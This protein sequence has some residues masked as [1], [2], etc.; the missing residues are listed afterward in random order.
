[1][2]LMLLILVFIVVPIVELWLILQVAELMGGGARGAALT[3]GLLV[4]DSLLGAALLRSQGRSVWRQF[5]G[6]IDAR[7]M[8]AREIVDG[9]FVIVGGVL[10]LTPGFLSDIVGILMLIP[11]TRRIFGG[12]VIGLLSSRVRPAFTIADT[13]LSNFQ[14]SRQSRRW[15][16]EAEDVVEHAQ[17]TAISPPEKISSDEPDFDFRKQRPKQ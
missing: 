14:R 13:G 6:A 17:D 7:R 12:W 10:L 3:I 11:P 5:T 16:H 9:G 2:P 8:P 4:A 1:M 15:D